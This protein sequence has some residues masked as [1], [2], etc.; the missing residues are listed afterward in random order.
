MRIYSL[1]SIMH[2]VQYIYVQYVYLYIMQYYAYCTVHIS[3]VCISIHYAVLYS[4]CIMYIRTVIMQ[5]MLY[6]CT[7]PPTQSNTHRT[8]LA[9]PCIL[10]LHSLY[11]QTL[12]VM[13]ILYKHTLY[14]QLLTC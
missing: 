3:T 9:L 10:H 6:V 2:T 4:T 1:C 12:Y 11:T 13:C 14:I 5:F 8:W 7:H